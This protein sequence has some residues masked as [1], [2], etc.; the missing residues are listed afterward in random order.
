MF[1]LL[2]M[3][4]AATAQ[5]MTGETVPQSQ[6]VLDSYF[7]SNAVPGQLQYW[8]WIDTTF[9]YVMSTYTN[10]QAAAQA[11]Q[12]SAA[13]NKRAF[14]SMYVAPGLA[15]G[16]VQTWTYYATNGFS[17]NSVTVGTFNPLGTE[18]YFIWFTNYFT[19]PTDSR[20]GTS[21]T[22]PVFFTCMEPQITGGIF[23]TNLNLPPYPG[24][25]GNTP[26]S[27]VLTTNYFAFFVN[28]GAVGSTFTNA[29]LFTFYQ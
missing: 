9:Y 10:A 20:T 5:N 25:G 12:A 29:Y 11:A 22:G 13:A 15:A 19:V 8:E 2:C 23:T 3:A 18:L 7:T 17:S 1:S 27:W 21:F 14:A 6:Q 4:L 28:L 16:P 24:G 26:T